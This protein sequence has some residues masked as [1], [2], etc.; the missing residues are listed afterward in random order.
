MAIGSE[1]AAYIPQQ[2]LLGDYLNWQQ[3]QRAN[4]LQSRQFSQE[5][6]ASPIARMAL[7]TAGYNIPD[8]QQVPGSMLPQIMNAAATGA[9]ARG[10][11]ISNTQ[12]ENAIPDQLAL[13]HA[14]A[15]LAG[16]DATFG[17]Q[18]LQP[19][20]A[21]LGA[22]NTLLGAQAGEAA[23]RGQY[24][25]S[26]G[27]RDTA[28]L[29]GQIQG[30]QAQTEATRAATAGTQQ[31]TQERQEMLPYQQRLAEGNIANVGAET[32][33]KGAEAGAI[34]AHTQAALI[35]ALGSLGQLSMMPGFAGVKP[36][37]S[38]YT[39]AGLTGPGASGRTAE[40]QMILD[41]LSGKHSAAG[42]GGAVASP[43]GTDNPNVGFQFAPTN[44]PM[45]PQLAG[46]G[47][48]TEDTAGKQAQADAQ[49]KQADMV[50]QLT[51][52]RQ[53]GQVLQQ[54]LSHLGQ[55]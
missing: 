13:L 49:K 5:D 10:Q 17:Q 12:N 27:A 14:H 11:Q 50:K 29:P 24:F 52:R 40:Q 51:L 1:G 42:T 6:Q 8:D 48:M 41:A 28:L 37:D 47:L 2:S 31:Q 32:R 23:G 22:Q 26:E 39:E 20:L 21:G 4:A 43:G 19:R 38:L 46:T 55:F 18:S 35:G 34:P 16:S 45:V 30:Q 25:A 9:S 3:N 53:H 15:L 7:K 36:S 54:A 33:L 44:G